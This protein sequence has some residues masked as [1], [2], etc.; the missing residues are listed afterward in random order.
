[1]GIHKYSKKCIQY[2]LLL[3]LNSIL[4]CSHLCSWVKHQ[5]PS[6]WSSLFFSYKIIS[7]HPSYVCQ[8]LFYCCHVTTKY[9]LHC[10][11]F[12]WTY[13]RLLFYLRYLWK[14]LR[15]HLLWRI[16]KFWPSL[17]PLV[18][19]LWWIPTLYDEVTWNPPVKSK[20]F[21]PTLAF[22]F[23]CWQKSLRLCHPWCNFNS[24][25][26]VINNKL[27]IPFFQL[28]KLR[29]WNL[30]SLQ[31]VAVALPVYFA[32]R[33]YNAFSLLLNELFQLFFK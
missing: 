28:Y 3:L 19:S 1:M 22:A 24:S 2:R 6:Q 9:S 11:L 33:R 16:R 13:C 4:F 26:A 12:N 15:L 7:A 17:S 32:T 18:Q 23:Q 10:V 30:V 21:Y 5:W 20:S 25:I 29:S 8:G 14:P 27:I 31:G